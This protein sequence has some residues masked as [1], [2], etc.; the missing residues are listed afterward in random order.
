MSRLSW[1]KGEKSE[2]FVVRQ[3]ERKGWKIL[4]RNFR[5]RGFEIDII[6]SRLDRLLCVEVKSRSNQGLTD[7][8][9]LLNPG[10]MQRLCR[11][12]NTWLQTF[13]PEESRNTEFWLCLVEKA[14]PIKSLEV[15]DS[16]KSRPGKEKVKVNW[17]RWAGDEGPEPKN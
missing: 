10:K 15:R 4:A 1:A 5:R 6:A 7:V 9:S 11:G 12:M 14:I 2:E 3:L 17:M 8:S 16:G 13:G